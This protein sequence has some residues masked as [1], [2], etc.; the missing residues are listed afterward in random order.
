VKGLVEILGGEVWIESE[1]G[2]GSTFFFSLPYEKVV[3]VKKVVVNNTDRSLSK[4]H[5]TIFIAEDELIIFMYLKSI[6]SEFN[7]TVLHSKNGRDAVRIFQENPSIDIVLMD[8]NMPEM[9][10]YEAMRK[11]KEL[12]PNMPIIAQSGLAMSGDKEKIMESGFDDYISKPISRNLLISKINHF[13]RK[14][15]SD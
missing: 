13:L 11:I 10:G 8:I 14:S 4:D 5:F 9:D 12:N 3:G 6:L 2:K 7:C 15:E 1:I